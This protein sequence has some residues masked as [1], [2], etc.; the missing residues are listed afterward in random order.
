LRA[1]KKS[2][3]KLEIDK[4]KAELKSVKLD[5]ELAKLNMT[6]D[7]GLDLENRIIYIFDE[8]DPDMAANVIMGLSHL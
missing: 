7:R 8:I 2:D 6:F 4:L 3:D 1:A 5:A